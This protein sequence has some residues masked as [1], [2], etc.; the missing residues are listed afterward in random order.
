MPPHIVARIKEIDE[1]TCLELDQVADACLGHYALKHVV[2]VAPVEEGHIL[3]A[4]LVKTILEGDVVDEGLLIVG[5]QIARSDAP[6]DDE[7]YAIV[8]EATTEA[9]GIVRLL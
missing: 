7:A 5:R 9:V 1:A 2:V 8:E 6:S 4:S 3:P